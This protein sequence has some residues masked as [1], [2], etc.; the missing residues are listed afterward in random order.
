MSLQACE[1]E[2]FLRS[3]E[4]DVV[5]AG[6]RRNRPFVVL[7]DIILYPEGGG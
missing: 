6:K 4:I 5:G 2:P 3:S 7:A 1:R